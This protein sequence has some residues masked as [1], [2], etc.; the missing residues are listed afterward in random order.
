MKKFEPK[1]TN[2]IVRGPNR[3]TYDQEKIYAILDSHYLGYM[4]YAHEGYYITIPMAYG[5]HGDELYIHGS[6]KNRLLNTLLASGKASI[7]VTHLDGLV[8]ARSAF[9]HSA[10]YRSATLFGLISEI[11]EDTDKMKAL[12][13]IVNHMVPDHWDFIRQPNDK[14]LAATLVAK[15]TIQDASAKVREEGPIDEKEDY[16]LP[17]WAGVLPSHL[18]YAE[19]QPDHHLPADISVPESVLNFLKKK[20]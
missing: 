7:T 5:R 15:I 12:R 3:G 11:D 4:A 19:P 18:A 20:S 9:H 6:R 10:N 8:L 13:C 16:T 1:S 17:I 14:E 2:K